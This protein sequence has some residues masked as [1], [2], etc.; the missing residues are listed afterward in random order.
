MYPQV[1]LSSSFA[2]Q[3]ERLRNR[4]A[5]EFDAIEKKKDNKPALILALLKIYA[6]DWHFEKRGHGQ[7]LPA[8]YLMRREF[9]LAWILTLFFHIRWRA[10]RFD[11]EQ[12]AFEAHELSSAKPLHITMD[13]PN[14]LKKCNFGLITPFNPGVPAYNDMLFEAYL[15]GELRGYGKSYDPS[16]AARYKTVG[17]DKQFF[18]AY[19][20]INE[21]LEILPLALRQ[22]RHEVVA[23]ML[24]RLRNILS[25]G[26]P[27]RDITE[28]PKH[29]HFA[30]YLN[31][32]DL[33]FQ[34][35][36]AESADKRKALGR[37]AL[38]WYLETGLRSAGTT[39]IRDFIAFTDLCELIGEFEL[40]DEQQDEFLRHF[41]KW[42][43]HASISF[44]KKMQANPV[45]PIPFA[46]RELPTYDEIRAL[47]RQ[48]IEKR[49]D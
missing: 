5:K 2:L 4:F 48:K 3:L 46:E 30:P 10:V 39:H 31:M 38:Y 26:E 25:L 13:E 37:E 47:Y 41:K 28:G 8:Y 29:R 21:L 35:R 32:Y 27:P 7:L 23:E 36:M 9:D 6:K 17:D 33:W 43:A 49:N 40:F 24:F 15:K 45:Q 42:A 1:D 18:M 16:P 12:S 14:L 44:Y 19:A 11:W 34:A 22:E 20:S